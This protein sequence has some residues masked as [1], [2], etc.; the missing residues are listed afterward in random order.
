MLSYD[1]YYGTKQVIAVPMSS[2][3][4]IDYM[5]PNAFFAGEDEPGYLVEYT[6]TGRPNHANHSNYVSWSPREVFEAAY[7]NS[8]ALSFG[9]AMMALME[10]K[11]VS[12]IGWNGKGM[13]LYYVPA[14]K[15]HADQNIIGVFPDDMVP[16]RDYIAMKT[17]NNEVVPWVASQSDILMSDW[18]ITG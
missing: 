17:V 9:H 10:G 6:G 2:H 18:C 4:Y 8:G 14:A 11:K 3:K 15:Y 7:E 12:R 1:L 16:Y 5:D 13:Y